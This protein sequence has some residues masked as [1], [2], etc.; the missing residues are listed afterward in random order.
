VAE[1]PITSPI[2]APEHVPDLR[3]LRLLY[4]IIF[5]LLAAIVARLWY[6][7][8]VE[9][10]ELA[11]QCQ[12]LQY[13]HIRRTAPRGLIEDRNGHILAA[14]RLRYII[15]VFP[16][17]VRKHPQTLSRLAEL[18]NLSEPDLQSQL[19]KWVQ[20]VSRY[21]PMPIDKDVDIK[22][23]I[24][25]EEESFDLPGVFITREPVR[26][27]RDDGLCSS[28]L[29]ITRPITSELYARWKSRGY[30]MNDQVGIFGLERTYEQMLRGQAGE[31]DYETDARGRILGQGQEIAPIPGKTLRLALD[32]GLQKVAAQAL[33]DTGHRG[34]VVALD[35]NNGGVLAFVSWPSYDL[36]QYGKIYGKLLKDPAH[37]LINRASDSAFACGSTFKPITATAG[38]QSGVITPQTQFYCPGYLR[39]GSRL[40]HCDEV[41]GTTGFYRAIGAS[42]N[43]YFFHVGLLAGPE[44]IVAWAKRYGLGSRT[45]I[46]IPTETPGLL[47]S[48]EW[49]KKTGRGP[50]YPG[51]TLNLSIGQ[52]YLRVSPLQLADYV[53]AIANGGTL[54]RP[55]FVDAIVDPITGKVQPVEPKVRGQIGFSLATRQAIVQGM[56]MAVQ[57]GGTAAGIA[58][59]GLS[60]AGKTGTAQAY[61]QGKKEDNA[62]FICFAPVQH[63][64]IAIAVMV[65]GGGYG[66]QAAAP[67]AQKMLRYYFFHRTQQVALV[68]R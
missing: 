32:F 18:L 2:E 14:N 24:R 8:V 53:A 29:G 43:V 47:P 58:I 11:E 37:P 27:Y 51:D 59:P 33:A 68:H 45:G 39:L 19:T 67:I 64:R 13:K 20:Q 38:L 31:T 48:P 10:K 56:E 44:A 16:D 36:N 62:F 41:H 35:P 21:D 22:T 17:D 50:W 42:C 23:L 46:D 54:W 57:P 40:F 60:I 55:H 28:F 9:G 61:S 5:L 63:P 7:Q 4:G 26:Y 6:L 52:G 3:R 12:N 65:E 49:K 66:A 34:A 25:V 30:H 1:K 15:S